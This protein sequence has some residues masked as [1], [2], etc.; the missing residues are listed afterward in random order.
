MREVW[1]AQ[2]EGY[3]RRGTNERDVGSTRIGRCIQRRKLGDIM[4]QK[5]LRRQLV[6][7]ELSE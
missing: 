1:E 3:K 7:G 2:T 5:C 4:R 6:V